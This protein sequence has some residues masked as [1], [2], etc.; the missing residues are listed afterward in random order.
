MKVLV[1][2]YSESG[3]TEKVARAIYESVQE[4]KTIKKIAEVESLAG[5]DLVFIGFPVQS[6]SVPV[7]AMSIFSMLAA[8]QKVALFSSHGS[9]R[10]GELPRQAIEHALGLSG[11]AMILGTFGCRGRV[12]DNIIS[13]LMKKPEH[14]AWAEE[15][16]GAARHPDENDLEDA[17]VFAKQMLSKV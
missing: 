8:G 1:A 12:S 9:L 11:K 5:Y 10:G 6:H 16:Q 14:K 7:K 15:A 3:N 2:Y 13:A 4:E 17:R